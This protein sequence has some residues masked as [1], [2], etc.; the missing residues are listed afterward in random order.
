MPEPHAFTVRRDIVRLRAVDR[1]RALAQS[2][3]RPAITSHAKCRRV[4]RIPPRVSD[5]PDT[6]L[7]GAGREGI[8]S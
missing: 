2:R 6:P 3:T 7:G 8:Y 5:D 4:H 1:S